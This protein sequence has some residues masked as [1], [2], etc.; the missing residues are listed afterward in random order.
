MTKFSQMLLT[1]LL[2][3]APSWGQN[4]FDVQVKGKQR[5]PAAEAERVYLSACATVV[6]EFGGGRVVRP[7]ITVV[8][9]TQRNEALLDRRE[10]HL[11]KWDPY[12]FAEGVVVFAFEELM[13][14]NERLTVTKRAVTAAE[15]TIE[16]NEISR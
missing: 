5:W 13:P 4:L 16:V 6:R 3:A 7:R 14:M 11:R 9:G 1:L 15:S 2:L 8:V 12:L 10:I